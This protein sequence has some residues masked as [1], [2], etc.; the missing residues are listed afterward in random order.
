MKYLGKLK[1]LILILG[2]TGFTQVGQAA[3][4][5]LNLSTYSFQNNKT[6]LVDDTNGNTNGIKARVRAVYRGEPAARPMRL[7]T[8]LQCP[9]ESKMKVI[10]LGYFLKKR[11]GEKALEFLGKPSKA[12]PSGQLQVCSLENVNFDQKLLMVS[13]LKAG[14]NGCDQ[15]ATV[16]LLFP[17]ADLCR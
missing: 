15:R 17:I 13:I 4:E 6:I 11:Y 2:C 12:Y 5:L 7:S 14:I 9:G 1:L 8:H 10:D 16:E 3:D